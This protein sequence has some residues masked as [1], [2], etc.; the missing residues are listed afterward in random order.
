MT[1]KAFAN[2]GYIIKNKVELMPGKIIFQTL[3]EKIWQKSNPGNPGSPLFDLSPY[4]SLLPLPPFTPHPS[5]LSHESSALF[6]F[7]KMQ[8]APDHYLIHGAITFLLIV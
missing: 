3:T 1:S 5:K 2:W 4:V 7:H 8:E 6:V